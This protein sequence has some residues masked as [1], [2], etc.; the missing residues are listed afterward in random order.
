MA[1]GQA[2]PGV[3]AAVPPVGAIPAPGA[4]AA[5]PTP[6]VLPF[7]G[8]ASPGTLAAVLGGLGLASLGAAFHLRSRRKAAQHAV[9]GESDPSAMGEVSDLPL[10]EDQR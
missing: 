6:S 10:D 3:A 5:R 2:R 9:G 8:Q 4:A 7:A 1:P